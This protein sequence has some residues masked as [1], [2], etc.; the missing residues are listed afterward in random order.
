MT[1]QGASLLL[2]VMKDDP[3][4][5]ALAGAHTAD[6]VAHVDTIAALASLDRP[7]MDGKGD[8]VSLLERDNFDP[9]LHAG[10]LLC[11]HELSTGKVT[12]GL[13]EQDCHLDGKGELAIEILMQAIEIPR[14]VLQQQRRW[15]GLAGI[16][17]ESEKFGMRL[18]VASRNP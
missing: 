4:R 9:A 15:S 13:R 18:R 2:G 17:A 12:S 1:R 11:Q 8:R 3:D 6:P 10:A 7:V 14:P 5:V 16:M